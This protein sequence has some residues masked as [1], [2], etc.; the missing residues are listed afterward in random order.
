MLL[1]GGQHGFTCQVPSLQPCRAS[2]PPSLPPPSHVCCSGQGIY[3]EINKSFSEPLS[4]QVKVRKLNL[5][6]FMYNLLEKQT[7]RTEVI[8]SLPLGSGTSPSAVYGTTRRATLLLMQSPHLSYLI[9]IF[10]AI[11]PNNACPRSKGEKA[12]KPF[13]QIN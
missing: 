2:L 7:R 12:F 10:H 8:K 3:K 5:L 4:P 9:Y 6:L 11:F 13:R 1:L